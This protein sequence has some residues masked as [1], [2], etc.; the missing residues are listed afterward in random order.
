[1]QMEAVGSTL[2]T[3]AASSTRLSV[4]NKQELRSQTEALYGSLLQL[5]KLMTGPRGVEL[6]SPSPSAPG[7]RA[8]SEHG[9]VV[10]PGFSPAAL[11]PA[12]SPSHAAGPAYSDN[13]T[14][15]E[16]TKTSSQAQLT[17]KNRLVA[18]DVA[19]MAKCIESLTKS[20]DD[21]DLPGV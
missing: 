15:A 18:E 12:V 11:S 1:M 4:G 16:E 19:W 2:N 17:P 10:P 5:H 13:E 14:F 3:L 8:A 7:S 9:G 20:L 6:R 21:L